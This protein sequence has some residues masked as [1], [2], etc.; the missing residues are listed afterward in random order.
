MTVTATADTETVDDRDPEVR[1][2]ALFDAGTMRP[3]TG[4]DDS[5]VLAARGEIDGT[6]AVAFATDAMKMG[7]AKGYR[8]WASGIP[9]APGWPRV[10][11]RWTRSVRSSRRWCA[12]PAGYP[13]SRWCSARRPVGR[14]TARRSPTS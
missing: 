10:W 14:P 7:G 11:W 12:H 13:R 9:A 6:P 2:R 8:S 1:L 5:G 3:L 4:R